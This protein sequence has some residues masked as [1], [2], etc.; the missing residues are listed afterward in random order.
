MSNTKFSYIHDPKNKHRI[1]TI[2]RVVEDGDIYF[3]YS[4]N[5]SVDNSFR[6]NMFDHRVVTT[7]KAHAID[8]FNKKLGRTIAEGRLN[9]NLGTIDGLPSVISQVEDE[10]P[11]ITILKHLT[12]SDNQLVRRMCKH[13]LNE[14]YKKFAIVQDVRF[15]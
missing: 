10:A 12:H 14:G 3:G 9:R 4:I 6:P 7:M 8:Q 13:Y 2:A 1:M 11:H 5:R 15:A